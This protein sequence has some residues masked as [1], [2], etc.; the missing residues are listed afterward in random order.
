MGESSDPIPFVI[1]INHPPDVIHNTA[2]IFV[3]NTKVLHLGRNNRLVI[4]KMGN[5]ELQLT[6]ANVYFLYGCKHTDP[7][8]LV[9][10]Y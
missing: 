2:H 5:T 4:C 10:F 7:Y 8:Y 3:D 6:E 1:F 9:I